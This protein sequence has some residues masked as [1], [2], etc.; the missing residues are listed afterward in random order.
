[1][2]KIRNMDFFCRPPHSQTP[3]K[4]EF[5]NYWRSQTSA[6]NTHF[7]LFFPM[8]D[9]RNKKLKEEAAQGYCLKEVSQN[10]K[11]RV[12]LIS[13]PL[14]FRSRSFPLMSKTPNGI[15]RF[16]KS[17]VWPSPQSKTPTTHGGKRK[18]SWTLTWMPIDPSSSIWHPWKPCKSMKRYVYEQ[19]T[20]TRPYS[21]SSFLC[22]ESR[23]EVDEQESGSVDQWT[24]VAS[25][26]TSIDIIVAVVDTLPNKLR[27]Y[28]KNDGRR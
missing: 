3:T 6:T 7:T 10:K 1:M 19:A 8:T 9:A 20:H 13:S 22:R 18:P 12:A 17:T 2:K 15:V 5:G 11:F 21:S 14:L 27:L 16:A 26:K 24:I 28:V 23:K 25:I 4:A